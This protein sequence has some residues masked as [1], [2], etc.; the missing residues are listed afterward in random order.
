[1]KK[2]Y[3][4]VPIVIG[5]REPETC[6][7]IA[8]ALRPYLNTKNLF[9]ISTDFSHYPMYDDAV[10]V[11]KISADAILLNSA[12]HLIDVTR[13]SE[14]K[15]ITN[16]L[17]TM[18]GWSCVL[19]LLY[20]TE[21]STD[22]NYSLI[23]YKNS[24]DTEFGDKKRV[25]GYNAIAV[26]LKQNNE[27]SNRGLTD[28]SK[29]DLLTI[30]RNAIEHYVKERQLPLIDTSHLSPAAKRNGGTFVTLRKNGELRGCIGRFDANDPL[31]AVVQ[32]MA[33]AAATEDY[34][35]PQVQPDEIAGLEIEISALT[36]M[37]KIASIDE[38]K[39]GRHGIYIKRGTVPERSCPR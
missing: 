31:Y 21:N 28:K 12:A 3:R 18:C 37:R 22:V 39:L 24:G 6:K 8:S 27:G 16:L 23:Q 14:Q 11:D 4:I 30:A 29:R 35:F 9:I 25:V 36:P 5:A 32:H 26:S 33:I 19:T 17:T 20:M 38:I 7:E 13:S 15:G 2:N 34:R 10:R 1:M